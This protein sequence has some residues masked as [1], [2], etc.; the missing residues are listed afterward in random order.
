MEGEQQLTAERTHTI[1]LVGRELK[2]ATHYVALQT[3]LVIV[4]NGARKLKVNALL[5]DASAKTYI[6]SDVASELGLKGEVREL[7]V[8]VMNGQEGAFKP[9]PVEFNL[10][11]VDGKTSTK[12]S[13][14]TTDRVTSDL[15]PIDWRK[16]SH[17]WPHLKRL[18]FPDIGPRPIIDILSEVDQAELH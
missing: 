13:G 4:I 8:N 11:N 3:I 1:T 10:E 18:Q 6:N 14:F 15:R 16:Q 12:V 9:T 17:N 5:D 2:T 7:T